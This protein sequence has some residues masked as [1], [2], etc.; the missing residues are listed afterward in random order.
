MTISPKR[1]MSAV[2]GFLLF[3][4]L[5]GFAEEPVSDAKALARQALATRTVAR[6]A[7][8]QLDEMPRWHAAEAAKLNHFL[9]GRMLADLPAFRSFDAGREATAEVL[10]GWRREWFLQR[11]DEAVALASE[12]SPI[13]V[14]RERALDQAA[15]DW[16]ERRDRAAAQFAILAVEAVYETAREAA[17]ARRRAEILATRVYP[18]FEELDSR[19]LDLDK[20]RGDAPVPLDPRVF[21]QLEEWLHGRTGEVGPVF[22]EMDGFIRELG[23]SI[24]EEIAGQYRRQAE[25]LVGRSAEEGIPRELVTRPMVGAFLHARLDEAVSAQPNARPPVYPVFTAIRNLADDVAARVELRRFERFL[26]DHTEWQPTADALRELLREALA[27]HVDPEKSAGRLTQHWAAAAGPQVAAL[28]A[29]RAQADEQ[30]EAQRYFEDR[31]S[32]AGGLRQLWTQQ[33]RDAVDRLLPE[34]R[35]ALADEQLAAYFPALHQDRPLPEIMVT[36]LYDRSERAVANFDAALELLGLDDRWRPPDA[37]ME[38]W[39]WETRQAVLERLHRQTGPA[40]DALGRQ[41]S[42]VQEI[43]T[44]WMDR[45]RAEVEDGTRVERVLSR[46]TAEWNR[47]WAAQAREVP[48]AWRNRFE[49]T[50]DQLNKTVRQLYTTVETTVRTAETAAGR[51]TSDERESD[52]PTGME[53]DPID[54]PEQ[55]LGEDEIP[56]EEGAG[57][58]DEVEAGM[59]EELRAWRGVADGVLVFSDLPDGRCRMVFGAPDGSGPMAVEFDPAAIEDSAGEI[60]K[61]LSGIL[62][63]LLETTAAGERSGG[64]FFFFSRAR[65][66]E[67]TMLFVVNSPEIRHQMSIEVRRRIEEAVGDW[68][69]ETGQ[70]APRLQWQEDLGSREAH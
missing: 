59:A 8:N 58:G 7:L 2:L 41:L 70:T 42:L 14:S 48:E 55:T 12:Q 51:E 67:L 6:E 47:R 60:A 32:V 3:G 40:V 49:R 54:D 17:I 53:M 63:R 66:P 1:R 11:V 45:L 31:L 57:A 35:S 50:E 29:Q 4:A 62:V 10:D 13:P 5:I 68:A 21:E 26:S 39:I 20:R 34:I 61:A 64:R 37:P 28:Y 38:T 16:L 19:L 24:R 18:G 65:E 25:L 15:P 30:S 27:E 46:W 69:R 23:A 44:E 43:E 56:A 36:H 9:A 52:Q 33:V 22:E